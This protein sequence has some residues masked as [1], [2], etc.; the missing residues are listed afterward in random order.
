[1]TYEMIRP[2]G[3]GNLLVM[4][5]IIAF[6]FFLTLVV[7]VMFISSRTYTMRID[8][9]RVRIRSVFYNTSIS[10]GDIRTDELRMVKYSD[11]GVSLRTNGLALPGLH[12]G[13][14]RGNGEKYKLYVTDEEH[15]LLIP[16]NLGYAIA[17]STRDG[18]EII[19]EL[20]E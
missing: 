2:A 14:F 4:L 7:V 19:A 15:I 1:M 20:R 12:I 18:D 17:F 6:L 11:L 10:R 13:W 3:N 8:A 9:D 16:T 5:L